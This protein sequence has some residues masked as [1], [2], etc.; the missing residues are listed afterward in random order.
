MLAI[1][2]ARRRQAKPQSLNGIARL[3]VVLET[4]LGLGAMAGG[5]PLI[6]APDGHLLG[7]P[8]KMLAGSP[9]HTYLVPG[10]LLFTVIG[11]APMLV[12]AITVRHH[13]LAPLAAVAVGLT[14]IV[15]ISVEMVILNGPGSLAWALYLVL[16]SAIAAIG[17]AWLR[18][19][20]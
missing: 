15:W 1:Q 17:I 20:R 7:M 14:L 19:S 16:G 5:A 10:I 6:L 8:T 9:F 18:Y 2:N 4:F 3:A 13:P 11:L 12:A